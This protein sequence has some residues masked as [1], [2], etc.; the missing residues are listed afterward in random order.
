MRFNQ[1][2]EHV[3]AF[4]E[5][6]RPPNLHPRAPTTPAAPVVGSRQDPRRQQSAHHCSM[7]TLGVCV[8]ALALATFAAPSQPARTH[9]VT[10]T[11]ADAH[12][13][14]TGQCCNAECRNCMDPAVKPFCTAS[15]QDCE[16]KC[17]SHWCAGPS[18]SPPPSPTPAPPAPPGTYTCLS[19]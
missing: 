1:V 5:G 3:T 9:T 2:A 16:E 18:P 19:Q 8:C 15:Q 6:V 13:R 10:S 4:L 17:N 11:H 14:G 7:A 12:R